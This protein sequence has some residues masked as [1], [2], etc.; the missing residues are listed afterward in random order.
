MIQTKFVWQID[1][2]DALTKL[3]AGIRNKALR[4]SLN[5]AAAPVKAAVIAAAPKDLGTLAQA[6]K[7][8][9]KNYR[10]GNTWVAVVGA[11][12]KF[13]RLKKHKGKVQKR[14][15]KRT[16]KK[17]SVYSRPALYQHFVDQGRKGQRGKHYLRTAFT[18]SQR[19]FEAVARRK[20]GEVITSLMRAK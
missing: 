9:V 12:T 20:L 6:T 1:P 4:I 10:K 13:K 16:G 3:S 2:V 5:A 17:V 19:Q 18:Q 7:I 15:D 8:K 14:F 11:G